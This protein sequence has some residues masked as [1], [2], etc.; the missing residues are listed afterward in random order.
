VPDSHLVPVLSGAGEQLWTLT[1]SRRGRAWLL[2]ITSPDNTSWAAGGP[3]LFK[4]LRE[5]RRLLEPLDIRL[6]VNGARRDAWASGMQCDMGEGRVVYLL[7][8]GQTGR[9]AQVST[10][11]PTALEYV[12]TLDEQ[13]EQYARWLGSRR[14]PS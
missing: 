6:G 2:T 13:D 14:T 1:A 11:G 3:D 5:L 9:P 8:E 7:V 12:G 10:I 4:A